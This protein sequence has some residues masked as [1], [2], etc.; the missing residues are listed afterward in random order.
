MHRPSRLLHIAAAA[1]LALAGASAHAAVTFGASVTNANGE[2]QTTLT[3]DAPGASSCIAA[4]HPDW[5][6]PR[7]ARGEQ[8]MPPLTLSGTYT[9]TLSCT[10]PGDSTA[11]LTWEPPTTNTDGTAYT[12]PAGVIVY[13][14]QTENAV[15]QPGG[16]EA[17]LTD[18]GASAHTFDGL[19]PGEWFFGVRVINASGATSDLQTRSPSGGPARKVITAASVED[20]SVT[21]TVN[22][23]PSRA[24]PI[25]VE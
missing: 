23:V 4:G 2:L 11:R 7:P 10:T 16:V 25:G 14:A 21:L 17:R 13:A 8:A 18:G 12:N 6:G 24:G 3:W 19:A 20:S 15:G 22:P 9:L 1:A 5:S